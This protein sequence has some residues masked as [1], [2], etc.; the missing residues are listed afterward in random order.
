MKKFRKRKSIKWILLPAVLAAAI[1]VP[2]AQADPWPFVQYENTASVSGGSAHFLTGQVATV[3]VVDARHQALVDRHRA[4]PGPLVVGHQTQSGPLAGVIVDGLRYQAMAKYYAQAST[5]TAGIA[6]QNIGLPSGT[7]TYAPSATGTH[8][9]LQ[10]R[11]SA[12]APAGSSSAT[13]AGGTSFG[14][15]DAATGFGVAIGIVLLSVLGVAAVGV[16]NRAAHA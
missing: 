13:P 10:P 4:Q 11:Q 9:P 2:A 16:R 3:P 14:W 6:P 5:P 8:Q 12:P 1:V 15:G 7:A